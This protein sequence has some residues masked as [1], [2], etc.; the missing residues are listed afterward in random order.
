[1]EFGLKLGR[2]VALV[3]FCVFSSRCVCIERILA[4]LPYIMF[5]RPSVCLSVRLSGTGVH[6][7]HTVHVQLGFKFTVGDSNVLGTL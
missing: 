2:K 7:D 5:V 6:C 1:M 3:V 4:L